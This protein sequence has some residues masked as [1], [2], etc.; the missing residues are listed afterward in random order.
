MDMWVGSVQQGMPCCQDIPLVLFRAQSRTETCYRGKTGSRRQPQP[1]EGGSSTV[2]LLQICCG[3]W[4]LRLH[5]K[6]YGNRPDVSS[7]NKW[8]IVLLLGVD[9]ASGPREPCS[10]DSNLSPSSGYSSPSPS[11]FGR[12]DPLWIVKQ[13]HS[14]NYISGLGLLECVNVTP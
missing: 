1:S 14:L 3:C 10:G 6:R 5:R 12:C 7:V 13:P 2:H 4:I 11:S 8:W 9:G